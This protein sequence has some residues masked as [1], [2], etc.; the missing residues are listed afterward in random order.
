MSKRPKV[1]LRWF[2]IYGR[3]GPLPYLDVKLLWERSDGQPVDRWDKARFF[4]PDL[5]SLIFVG[6]PFFLLGSIVGRVMW[7]LSH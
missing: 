6:I 7:R 4:L 3:I 1:K 5:W 2:V